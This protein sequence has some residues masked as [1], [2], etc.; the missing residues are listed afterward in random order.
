MKAPNRESLTM[1]FSPHGEPGKYDLMDF[2]GVKDHSY[3]RAIRTY[4]MNPTAAHLREKLVLAVIQ[5]VDEILLPFVKQQIYCSVTVQIYDDC[6]LVD[7]WNTNLDLSDVKRMIAY[8]CRSK[9]F[10]TD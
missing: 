4:S 5:N 9:R 8:E 3:W 1:T 10:V 7:G 2:T 6:E